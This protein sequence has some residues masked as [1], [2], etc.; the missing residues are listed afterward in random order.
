MGRQSWQNGG[1]ELAKEDAQRF[2]LAY[3]EDGSGVW[4]ADGVGT[5]AQDLVSASRTAFVLRDWWAGGAPVAG[6]SF[7][8]TVDPTVPWVQLPV[9]Y[10]GDDNGEGVSLTNNH[11]NALVDGSTIITAQA[12]GPRVDLG[13]GPVD[14]LAEYVTRELRRAGYRDIVFVDD[15]DAYH[16]HTGSVHCATNVF[17]EIPT[18]SWWALRE[19][20]RLYRAD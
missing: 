8:F 17:R 12:H 18:A 14:I 20:T 9:L 10:R 11:V 1:A 13:E 7:T 3:Q 4:T 5:M 16:N 2:M 19:S 6:D 15:R